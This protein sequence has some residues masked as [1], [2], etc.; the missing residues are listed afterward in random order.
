MQNFTLLQT[1]ADSYLQNDPLFLILRIRAPNWKNAP[2]FAS[3]SGFPINLPSETIGFTKSTE[4]M[5]Q[6]GNSDRYKK[7]KQI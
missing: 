4:G 1:F 3:P 2:F 6:L 7:Q 5:T